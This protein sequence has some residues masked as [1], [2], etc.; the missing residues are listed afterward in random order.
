VEAVR[1]AFPDV[2][3]TVEEQVA[4]GATVAS[5]L[6]ARG[7]HQG[8]YAGVPATG[9]PVAWR[10]ATFHRFADGRIA[11]SW[12]SFDAAVVLEQLGAGTRTRPS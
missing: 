9:R 5:R 4:E 7:T 6:T 11:D 3:F 8:P 10:M 2:V 12:T 1:G